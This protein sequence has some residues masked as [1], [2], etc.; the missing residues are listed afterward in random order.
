MWADPKTNWS[1]EWNGETY[2]GDYFYIQ[3]ITVLKIIFWN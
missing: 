1:S 2:I 3:I